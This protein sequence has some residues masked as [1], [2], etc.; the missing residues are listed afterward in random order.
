MMINTGL[1]AGAESIRDSKAVSTACGS[2]SE[3]H[4]GLKAGV[5][6]KFWDCN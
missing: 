3:I 2:V 5:N 6:E 4:T 1:Q